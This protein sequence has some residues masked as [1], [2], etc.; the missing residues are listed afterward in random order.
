MYRV[1]FSN[2]AARSFRNL[3][4]DAQRRLDPTIL[5]LAEN[6]R[7]QG[8]AKLSGEESLWRVRVGDYRIIYQIQDKA[9]LV[10]VV[11]VGHRREIYR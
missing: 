5:A 1:E 3:S 8:C 9:L 7:P 6:P 10:L 2:Q 11:K 4:P